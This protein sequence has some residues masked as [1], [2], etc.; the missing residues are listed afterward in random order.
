MMASEL[1]NY[2]ILLEDAR[3]TYYNRVSQFSNISTKAGII[4]A[5][6]LGFVTI[7]FDWLTENNTLLGLKLAII[8]FLAYAA[9]LSIRA[10]F[11]KKLKVLSVAAG[12]NNLA[13]YPRMETLQWVKFLLGEYNGFIKEIHAEYESKNDL[14]K[15]ALYFIGLSILLYLIGMMLG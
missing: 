10:M 8:L 11:I 12:L 5:A 4:L 7:V 13:S 1:E 15:Q 6:N 9:Y 3:Q 2:K 14:L